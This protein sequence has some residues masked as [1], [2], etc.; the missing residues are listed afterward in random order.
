MSRLSE[1]T[2]A[3]ILSILAAALVFAGLYQYATEPQVS[4]DAQW[5]VLMFES[6]YA[7]FAGCVNYAAMK[8]FRRVFAGEQ[9]GYLQPNS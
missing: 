4:P 8:V 5:N 9:M 6:I 7:V 1:S 3:L 2:S